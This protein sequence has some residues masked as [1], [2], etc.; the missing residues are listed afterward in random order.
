MDFEDLRA[1]ILSSSFS[2]VSC[3]LTSAKQPVT[4]F[5]RAEARICKFFLAILQI[6]ITFAQMC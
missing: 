1:L 6:V 5:C 4:S 3:I 2:S